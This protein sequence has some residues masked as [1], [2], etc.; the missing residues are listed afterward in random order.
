[1]N[2]LAVTQ[3]PI[4]SLRPKH[5]Q[6]P[7]VPSVALAVLTARVASL[8]RDLSHHIARQESRGGYLAFVSEAAPRLALVVARLHDD[9]HHLVS[10]LGALRLKVLRARPS[11]WEELV[12]ETDAITTAIADHESL[13]SEL[14]A[15]ALELP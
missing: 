1:M 9:H 15:E 2:V 13:E 4:F 8:H 5:L 6:P 12:A 7:L 11:Q 10:S 14:L 3:D